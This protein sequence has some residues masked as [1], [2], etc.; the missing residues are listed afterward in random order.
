MIRVEVTSE[1]D[2]TRVVAAFNCLPVLEHSDYEVFLGEDLNGGIM[3]RRAWRVD[4]ERGAAPPADCWW[5]AK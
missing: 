4:G 5:L 1:A 3:A 2:V